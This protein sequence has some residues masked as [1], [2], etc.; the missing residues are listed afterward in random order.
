MTFA[1][2]FCTPTFVVTDG[3]FQ[4]IDQNQALFSLLGTSFGGDGVATFAVPNLL[5]V[6]AIGTGQGVA[7]GQS[8]GNTNTVNV[9]TAIAKSV[10]VPSVQSPFLNVTSCINTLGFY[11]V[12]Q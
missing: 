5:G 11:P 7:F 4:S 3:G 9:Q 6:T 8:S 12:S 10:Q 1:G 2:T